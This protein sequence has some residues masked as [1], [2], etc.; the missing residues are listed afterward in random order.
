MP[1]ACVTLETALK[2]GAFFISNKIAFDYKPA[3]YV[4]ADNI[5]AVHDWTDEQLFHALDKLASGEE[6]NIDVY[7]GE[8]PE[9]RA[10]KDG[11]VMAADVL[12]PDEGVR[13]D[14]TH[15]V[16]KV[17]KARAILEEAVKFSRVGSIE[18]AEDE[19]GGFIGHFDHNESLGQIY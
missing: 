16:Y 17:W 15:T 12:V 13:E 5:I 7:A 11:V 14:G 1:A 4:G 3:S 19:T 2:L 10:A 6:L 9:E 18:R 8:G